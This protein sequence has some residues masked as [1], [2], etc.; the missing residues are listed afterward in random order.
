MG[1]HSDGYDG[2][3]LICCNIS[4]SD[5]SIRSGGRQGLSGSSQIPP[6]PDMFNLTL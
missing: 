5:F 2:T 4:D 3:I 1:C 6:R